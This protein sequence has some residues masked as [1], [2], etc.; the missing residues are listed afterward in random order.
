M[1]G[2]AMA[3][4][5]L[6]RMSEAAPLLERLRGK[7]AV[8]VL[9]KG[10]DAQSRSELANIM[11]DL[12]KIELKNHEKE[13]LTDVLIKIV[14]QAERD[15]KIAL[16]ERLALE[17]GIP[18][19]M[20]L[21]LANDEIDIAAPILKNSHVLQDMDLVYLI[22]TH[23][24]EYWQAIAERNKMG[25]DVITTLAE[26]Y[27]EGTAIT[28]A[29]NENIILTDKAISIFVE[30]S[31]TSNALAKPLLVRDELPGIIG[32]VLYDYVA[33]EVREII[34]DRFPMEIDLVEP[35]IRDVAREFTQSS[36]T[37]MQPSR[38]T[39]N[40]AQKMSEHGQISFS[41]LM[42][43]LRRG[44][45]ATFAALLAE[46]SYLPQATIQEIL[47]QDNGQGL[48]VLS[49]AMNILKTDFI[50]MFLLTR[51]LRHGNTRIVSEKEIATASKYY[52]ML[53]VET[54]QQIL[55]D[56]RH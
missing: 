12:F 6:D 53:D 42:N 13:L 46:Y 33:E 52:D 29:E 11:L 15:L 40:T 55:S 41:T 49:R 1:R 50:S 54:A 37:P 31:K 38:L 20:I 43:V 39:I 17:P 47:R 18:L 26:T 36:E 48:A 45:L 4:D 3:S 51:R 35:H 25:N 16:S 14:R 8:Y 30:M 21:H 23:T 5:L 24:S 9:A 56:S 27:D 7:D 32:Q 28:L 22:K 2:L 10:K 34:R 44:Q 19:R